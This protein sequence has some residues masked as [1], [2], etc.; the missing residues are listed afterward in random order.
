MTQNA[1]MP[2]KVQGFQVFKEQL[3]SNEQRELVDDLRLAITTAPLFTP[4][5]SNGKKMSVQMTALGKYGWFSDANGYRYIPTH[6]NGL[7]WPS[8][9]TSIL[10]IWSEF[11]SFDRMPDCCLLNYYQENTKMGLH[12]DNDEADYKWP[13]LSISL[14]DD[15]LYRMGGKQRSDF[16]QSIWLSSGD[17]VLMGGDARLKYHGI[18]RIK[19]GTSRLLSHGGRI[20]LTLR[21]VD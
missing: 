18:D 7:K 4:T 9:P 21:V 8:I 1:K 17:I 2:L 12:L 19:F 20:N 6:P 13:V 14:G 10:K 11:V 15:A 3:D 5:M 16:T